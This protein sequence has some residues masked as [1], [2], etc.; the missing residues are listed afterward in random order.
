MAFVRQSA[1]RRVIYEL[2]PVSAPFLPETRNDL[3]KHI[4]SYSE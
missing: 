2:R 3:Y 4:A 1:D